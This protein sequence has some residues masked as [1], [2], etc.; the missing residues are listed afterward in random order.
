MLSSHYE[1]RIDVDEDRN[2]LSFS[3]SIVKEGV[4]VALP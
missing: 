4:L 3:E 1:S 2:S